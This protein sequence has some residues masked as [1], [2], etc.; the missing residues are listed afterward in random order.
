[1]KNLAEFLAARRLH[2]DEQAELPES[3][4]CINCGVGLQ[5]SELYRSFGVCNNCRFH[6]SV[7]AHRRIDLLVDPGSFRESNRSLI[8]VD[9]IGFRAQPH[10]RKRIYDEQRRTGLAD[11]IVT[12]TGRIAGRRVVV[13]AIDFRFLGGSIGCA[14]GE[15]LARAMEQG[16]RRKVPVVVFVAS[17]GVRMQE[18]VL[19]LMQFAK[20]VETAG[21]LASAGEPLIAVLAN[22]CLGGA[23]AVLTGLAD[24]VVAEPGAL[25]GYAST[26]AVELSSGRQ[27]PE[28]ARSSEAHLAHGID[29][30][31]DRTHLRDFLSSLLEMLAIRPSKAAAMDQ[32]VAFAPAEHNAWSSIQVS[33][34]AER[35]TAADYIGHFSDT[36]VELRGDRMTGDDRAIVA[37]IGMLG[38]EPVVYVGHERARGGDGD[39]PV[40][41]DGFRKAQRAYLLAERLHLPVVTFI[42]RAIATPSM[43]A[44]DAGL[45]TSLTACM[46][47]LSRVTTPIVAS[48]IGE[49]RGEA[50]L[51]LGIADRIVMLENAA[52]EVVSPEMA[53]S[54]IYRDSDRAD[55]VAPSLKPTAKDCKKLGIADVVVAEPAAG[56]HT[57]HDAAARLLSAA[58]LRAIGELKQ[59][60]PRKLVRAR[61]ERYRRIGQYSSFLS[62]TVGHDVA[63]FSGDI[64]RKAGGA[65]AR[66]T[67]RARRRP[68]QAP[69]PADE[70]DRLLV[71]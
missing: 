13:A 5:E 65:I 53:A 26:R 45:A 4:A 11:A 50:A 68:A 70:P 8:S 12:G 27:T 24:L 32:A 47:T 22:P 33:R 60:A 71:P 10:F 23:Y 56:A 57:D 62:T 49:G 44:E 9:P 37:G 69:R 51:A 67:R 43:R 42:D 35:P 25:V 31:V 52:F 7:G 3:G 21:R 17:G 54:I 19:A 46:T 20:L 59:S 1:M 6:Y 64:A 2:D 63:Q 61:Y 48:V 41:P 29:Q 40:Q 58:I 16:A 55:A 34:H 39:T 30:V 18:G 36:F 14:V 28:G 38:A 66:I 15:K